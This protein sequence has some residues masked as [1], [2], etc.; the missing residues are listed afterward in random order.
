MPF[1]VLLSLLPLR[2][3]KRNQYFSVS[4][5][6][7]QW[8]SGIQRRMAVGCNCFWMPVILRQEN[9]QATVK[10]STTANLIYI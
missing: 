7:S 8:V 10:G 3:E 5:R 2:I 6:T 9:T 4:Q 1:S